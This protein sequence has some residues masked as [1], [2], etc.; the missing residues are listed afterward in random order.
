M[1]KK[2]QK[3]RKNTETSCNCLLSNTEMKPETISYNH[4][5]PELETMHREPRQLFD[6]W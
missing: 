2:M 5:V 1:K 3:M 4:F 6:E